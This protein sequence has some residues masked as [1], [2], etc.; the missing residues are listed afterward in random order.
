MRLIFIIEINYINKGQ[1]EG[2]KEIKKI[3]EESAKKRK[4]IIEGNE[5]NER[6]NKRKRA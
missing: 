3:K 1:S 4:R 2:E 5:E 6:E